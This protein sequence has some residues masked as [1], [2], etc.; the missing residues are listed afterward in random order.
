MT[1]HRY[2]RNAFAKGLFDGIA[3]N[4]ESPA[5]VFS[6]LQYSRWHR[7]LVSKLELAPQSTVLDV[8]TGTGAIALRMAQGRRCSIVGLDLSPRMLSQAQC[9]VQVRELECVVKLVQGRAESLPFADNSF[10]V[11]VFSYLL[12]YVDSPEATLHELTRV[13]KPGGQMAS[14]EFYVPQGPV[15]HS[16]WLLHTRVVIPRGAR[17]FSPGWGEVGSFLGPSISN[18]YHRYPLPELCGLW[19]QVGIADVQAKVLSLGGA[20]VM[21]GRKEYK[22]G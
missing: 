2:G 12:R 11:V 20:V 16:L 4:Y 13:L 14:L 8:C 5:R 7:F 1:A 9:N 3:H 17:L 10:D 18:L 22:G 15:L 21:W 6:F 19:R